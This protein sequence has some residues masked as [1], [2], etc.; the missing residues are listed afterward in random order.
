[1][2]CLVHNHLPVLSL[3]L[4]LDPDPQIYKIQPT[5]N[6]SQTK[7]CPHTLC[8]MVILQPALRIFPVFN[9]K[10]AKIH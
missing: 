8:F 9:V 5:T 6:P 1:M 7:Y 3:C 10:N 4:V 2:L